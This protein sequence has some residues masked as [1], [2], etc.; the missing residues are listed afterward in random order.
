MDLIEKFNLEKARKLPV[1][2]AQSIELLNLV[3]P[4]C[5]RT[6]H[7]ETNMSYGL[8][9]A[10]VDIRLDQDIDLPPGEFSLASAIEKFNIP[11]F[12]VGLVLDK[13]TLA[14]RGLSVFNTLID[15]GFFGYLTLELSNRGKEHIYLP[16]ES[17][18]AQVMF[19]LL[20]EPTR[21]PYGRN[22]KYQNQERGP[23]AA[24]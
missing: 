4:L 5:P 18:I 7:I 19:H 3:Q 2:S 21:Q 12:I 24:R 11:D 23:Q 15:P 6:K 8:G 13:S 22:E 17:P 9:P 10:S 16:R 1:L 14:R 20:D